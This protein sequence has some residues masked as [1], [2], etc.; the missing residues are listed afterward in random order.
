MSLKNKV[1]ALALAS[2]LV[3]MTPMAAL[4][5]LIK[6]EQGTPVRLKLIDS[7]SSGRNKEGDSVSF[8]V[9]EDV[10]GPDDKTILIKEGAPAWGS[11]SMLQER[12]LAGQKGEISLTIEGTKAID[13]KKVPLR[14]SL[15]RQGASKQGTTLALALC[16]SWLF[17]FM[18]GKD[19]Q[20]PA[21]APVTAYIDRDVLVDA[22]LE[23]MDTAA[24]SVTTASAA[25]MNVPAVS[26]AKAVPGYLQKY[27]DK[28]QQAESLKALEQLRNQGVLTQQEFDAKKK[29]LT[30]NAGISG[31]K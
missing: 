1:F 2:S 15:N 13:G 31:L 24:K 17:V 6:L 12:A 25:V 5:D 28:G 18:K 14:A 19:A 16:V 22:K 20:I 3:L 10:M 8:Q 23:P 11:V 29:S 7:V 30:D 26:D 27:V 9:A 4:A 21:G